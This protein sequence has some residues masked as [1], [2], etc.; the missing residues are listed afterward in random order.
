MMRTFHRFLLTAAGIAVLSGPALAEATPKKAASPKA[1]GNLLDLLV[2]GDKPAGAVAAPP[3]V[4]DM[5]RSAGDLRKAAESF[6]RAATIMQDLAPVV[7]EGMVKGSAN[8]AA[9]SDSFDPFGFKTAFQTIREQGQ[10]IQAL[11]QAEIQ[12]LTE[13]CQR[14]RKEPA[15]R[16]AKTKKRKKARK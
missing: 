4:V 12:R 13:E 3:A 6:E 7:T 10:T 16:P 15:R 9:I 8:L 11:Q 5:I 2:A 1:K 14:L